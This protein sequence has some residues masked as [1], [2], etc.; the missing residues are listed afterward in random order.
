MNYKTI[1]DSGEEGS[2]T[3]HQIIKKI[4]RSQLPGKKRTERKTLQMIQMMRPDCEK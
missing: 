4:S 3:M 1:G 2:S